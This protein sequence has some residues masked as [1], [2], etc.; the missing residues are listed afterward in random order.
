MNLIKLDLQGT[1]APD[2]IT[3]ARKV[4][5]LIL[6]KTAGFVQAKAR[7]ASFTGLVDTLEGLV[8]QRGEA[9]AL[10]AG[11]VPKIAAAEVAV[12]REFT[13]LAT[14]A[15]QDTNNDP[16]E[17]KGVGF[18]VRAPGSGPTVAMPQVENL[19]VADGD[20]DGEVDL[21]WDPPRVNGQRVKARNFVIRH[22]ADINAPV[23]VTAPVFPTTSKATVPGLPMNVKQWF[24]VA[25]NGP[26]GLAPWSE[27]VAG[28]PV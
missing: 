5:D 9:L 2:K 23:W 15:E 21:T 22:C 18:E 11:L 10:A 1:S 16:G 26:D 14:D 20:V 27:P 25:A 19:H 6:K 4:A 7:L 28:T 17:I 8:K 12:D 3:F 13:N 24:Q